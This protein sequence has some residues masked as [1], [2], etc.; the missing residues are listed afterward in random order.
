MNEPISFVHPEDPKT[1][2]ALQQITNAMLESLAEEKA[3]CEGLIFLNKMLAVEEV[4]RQERKE[5]RQEHLAEQLA[6]MRSTEQ[7][8]DLRDACDNLAKKIE[9]AQTEIRVLQ[10]RIEVT[11]TNIVELDVSWKQREEKIRDELMH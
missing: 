9:A 8:V 4:Q 11:K 3:F 10:D 5:S 2:K 1:R 6:K 7:R